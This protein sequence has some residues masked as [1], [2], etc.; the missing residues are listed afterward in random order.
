[1]TLLAH[2]AVQDYVA[3][4]SELVAEERRR[5]PN[6]SWKTRTNSPIEVSG[7]FLVEVL[8]ATGL[9]L[10]GMIVIIGLGVV[11]PYLPGHFSPASL[12]WIAVTWG[13][14]LKLAVGLNLALFVMTLIRSFVRVLY[15]AA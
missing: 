10:L 13:A 3:P 2:G 12:H 6:F 15:R 8:R 5:S 14:L 11:D 4:L 9:F 7:Y 1:M